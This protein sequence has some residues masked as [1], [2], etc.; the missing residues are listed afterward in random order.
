MNE[1]GLLT[2]YQPVE[3]TTFLM[4][5]RASEEHFL[6]NMQSPIELNLIFSFIAIYFGFLRANQFSWT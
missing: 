5:S 4:K 2:K 1:L 3:I 6:G